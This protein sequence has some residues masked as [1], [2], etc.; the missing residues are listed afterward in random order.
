MK[1]IL[2]S[3][4]LLLMC[5]ALWSQKTITPDVLTVVYA[6]SDDGFLN[7]RERP[8]SKAKILDRLPLQFHGLGRGILLESG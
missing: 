2:L 5:S 7:V 6:T 4:G 8:S 3:F 1:R